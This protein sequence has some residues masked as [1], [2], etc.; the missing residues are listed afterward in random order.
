[1][2][3]IKSKKN[4][5]K[6]KAFQSE[7]VKKS[8]PEKNEVPIKDRFYV[9]TDEMQ[10]LTYMLASRNTRRFPLMHFD[11]KVN[12]ALRYAR[13]QKSPF[14]DEKDGNILLDPIVFEDG[15]LSVPKTNQA[16]QKFLELHHFN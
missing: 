9:L 12:R 7:T 16:L 10:P 2:E 14:E 6:E 15:F 5:S 4:K 8:A 1:M 11:G 3:K 13:N